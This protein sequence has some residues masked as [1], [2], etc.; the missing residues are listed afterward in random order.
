MT[1]AQD[2]RPEAGGTLSGMALALGS[3]PNVMSIILLV[4]V[5]PALMRHFGDLPNAVLWVPLLLTLP[6]ICAAGFAPVAGYLGDRFDKRYLL[7]GFA[8]AF[9]IFGA[10]PLLL[11][12]FRLIVLTRLA[13]GACQVSILILSMAVISDLYNGPPRDR[14]LSV[15]TM[16]ATFAAL[17]LL[18]VGG[19][20]GDILTWRGPFVVYLAGLP[21][22]VAYWRLGR[23][24]GA[25]H[26]ATP[27]PTPPWSALPWKWLL[28]FATVSIPA[29]MMFYALQLQIGLALSAAG[30]AT[31]GKIG[32]LSAIATI[33]IPAGAAL[34]LRMGHVPFATLLRMAVA[35]AALTLIAL[36]FCRTIPLFV[37]VSLVN[38]G[39]CGLMLPTLVTHL[40]R[41]LEP[42][43]R[44]RGIGVWKSA[45]SIGMFLTVACTSL[46]VKLSGSSVL[47]ALASLGGVVLV[48]VAVSIMAGA[49]RR[50][51]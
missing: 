19:W 18:P 11:N 7:A 46:I 6:G 41:N 13:V 25:T 42:A 5:M 40:S 47:I 29:A 17:L 35:V 36:P 38:L 10:A 27:A 16:A 33:G 14:W 30:V 21:L 12:D 26:S 4:P 20:L 51:A 45:F 32:L 3:V 28:G 8:F 22:A 2:E 50:S 49:A 39:A 37:V 44:A 1:A 15:Q 48:G 34:Y 31:A 23:G 43:V 9:A 24:S